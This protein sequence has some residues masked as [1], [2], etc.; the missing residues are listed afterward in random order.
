MLTAITQLIDS[1]FNQ[2]V[3]P[4]QHSMSNLENNFQALQV[5]LKSRVDT[6]QRDLRQEI[7]ALE[8]RIKILEQARQ[9]VTR[10]SEIPKDTQEHIQ[11]IENQFRMLQQGKCGATRADERNLTAVVHGLDGLQEDEAKEWAKD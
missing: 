3:D 1:K 4:L 2:K 8:E 7:H 9:D 10:T 5:D 6:L 11:R